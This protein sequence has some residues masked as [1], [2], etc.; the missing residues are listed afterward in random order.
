MDECKGTPKGRKMMV[1]PRKLLVLSSLKHTNLFLRQLCFSFLIY[2]YLGVY[3]FINLKTHTLLLY[4]ILN[5]PK[6]TLHN[7]R[8]YLS[9]MKF[10]TDK[11]QRNPSSADSFLRT[12]EKRQRRR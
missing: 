12:S 4:I 1:W 10:Q 5:E 6:S 9:K 8:N 11:S 7:R 3:E 2:T